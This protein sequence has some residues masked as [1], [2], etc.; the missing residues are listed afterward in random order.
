MHELRV[1]PELLDDPPTGPL[2]DHDDAIR[3]PRGAVVGE[4]AEDPLPA[5]EELGQVEVLDVEEGEDRRPVDGRDGD[6]EG[7]VDDVGTGEA[8]AM[9]T[10]LDRLLAQARFP[11]SVRQKAELVRGTETNVVRADA[12]RLRDEVGWAPQFTLDQTLADTLAYWR[13]EVA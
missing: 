7:V 11:I 1:E 5:G 10:V 9:Q 12:T 4:P 2:A 6:R 3:L 8:H 13:T